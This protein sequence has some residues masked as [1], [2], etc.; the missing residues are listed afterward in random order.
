MREF[1]GIGPDNYQ[2][3]TELLSGV[4]L[5]QETLALGVIEEGVPAAAM[6]SVLEEGIAS[7]ISFTVAEEFRRKGI[8]SELMLRFLDIAEECGAEG[9]LA[10]FQKDLPG[11]EPFLDQLG[12][13]TED[14]EALYSVETEALLSS[15][16]V[17]KTLE[18]YG[19]KDCKSLASLNKEEENEVFGLLV[20][21][22]YSLQDYV[23][24]GGSRR[25]SFVVI[26]EGKAQGLLLAGPIFRELHVHL[27]YD[28]EGAPQDTAMVLLA[29]MLNAVKEQE[30]L[31]EICFSAAKESVLSMVTSLLEDPGQLRK[32][33]EVRSSVFPLGVEGKESYREYSTTLQSIIERPNYIKLKDSELRSRSLASLRSGELKILE[34]YIRGHIHIGRNTTLLDYDQNSSAVIIRDSQPESFL[35][36][37]LTPSGKLR[38]EYLFFKAGQNNDFFDLLV[39]SVKQLSKEYPPETSISFVCRREA[40]AKLVEHFFPDLSYRLVE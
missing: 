38:L 2:Y 26:Q 24:L 18:R 40:G 3:F 9:V 5:R 6:A 19:N 23:D 21:A 20:E 39:Y 27:L 15:D 36:I 12:F 28:R 22:G 35:M 33:T 1:T 13:I 8:G 16:R 37:K 17:L 11:V 34:D 14:G 7:V 10:V 30:S 25:F 32:R 31:R 29:N 4:S